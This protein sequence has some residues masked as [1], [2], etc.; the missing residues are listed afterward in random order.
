MCSIEKDVQKFL[1]LLL[2]YIV[3][4]SLSKVFGTL[5]RLKSSF[6]TFTIFVDVGYLH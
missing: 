6:N 4:L 5:K 2:V 1:N 3:L